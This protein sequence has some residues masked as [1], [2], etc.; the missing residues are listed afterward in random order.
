MVLKNPALWYYLQSPLTTA[1]RWHT[2]SLYFP[3]FSGTGYSASMRKY[4]MSL[5]LF[6]FTGEENHIILLMFWPNY[7]GSLGCLDFIN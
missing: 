5:Y 1:V 6:T 2:I 7:F 3:L 4:I